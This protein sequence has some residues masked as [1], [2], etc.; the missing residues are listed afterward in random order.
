[1]RSLWRDSNESLCDNHSNLI[2]PTGASMAFH[3]YELTPQHYI[4]SI[5]WISKISSPSEWNLTAEEVAILLGMNVSEFIRLQ[6]MALEANEFSLRRESAERIS[7]LLGIW[8]RLQLL[9]FDEKTA[10]HAFN[11]VN[12]GELMKG[13]SIKIFLLENNSMA[14]FYAVNIYLQASNGNEFF[15]AS[16]PH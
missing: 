9:G 15:R 14:A 5:N 2:G 4:A 7:L 1:M 11:R 13:K 6:E 10:I 3:F 8:K 16:I 12:T